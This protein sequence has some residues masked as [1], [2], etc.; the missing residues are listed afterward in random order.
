MQHWT[1]VDDDPA[2]LSHVTLPGKTDASFE[3]LRIDLSRALDRLP[4]H[5]C[6]LITAS[7]LFDLV[8]R[9]WIARFAAACGEAR[10]PNGLFALNFDGRVEWSPREPEDAFVASVFL[11]DMRRDKGFG[12][13]SAEECPAALS[14]AFSA[15]GYRVR[16]TD[17]PWRLGPADS[18]LQRALL[19][20]YEEVAK[21]QAPERRRE[22]ADWAARRR[23]HL[24][25]GVS[26]LFVGHRDVLAALRRA[27]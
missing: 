20:G 15:A 4:L 16:L 24:A 18:A 26:A 7:A 5:G 23:A 10:V 19:D 21:R 17:T 12:T 8:S 22:I 3:T 14:D 13:A 1:L 6:D 27:S 9:D 2:V 11:R 25:A